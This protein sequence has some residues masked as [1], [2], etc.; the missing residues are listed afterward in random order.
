MAI[1]VTG[2]SGHLG[3]RVTEYLLE[4][5]PAEQLILVTRDPRSIAHYAEL[6]ATV[7]RGDFADRSSLADAFRGGTAML[8]IST[9]ALGSRVPQHQAAITAAAAAGIEFVAYTSF[10]RPDVA[11]PRELPDEH[12][13]TEDALKR[14]G[15]RWCI[16]RNS[17]YA[18]S[19]LQSLAI[20]RETGKLFTNYGTGRVGYVARDDCAAAAAA[21]L[22]TSGHDG[23]TYDVTGPEALDS[24]ARAEVFARVIG[25]PVEVVA[26]EAGADGDAMLVAALV[27]S[28]GLPPPAARMFASFGVAVRAGWLDLVSGSVADLTGRPPQTLGAAIGRA[29]QPAA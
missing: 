9:G 28:A 22:T 10:V 4:R 13:P 23:R 2:A 18:E 16:L 7:R 24:H 21:A 11:K 15:L 25:R 8:L 19:E 17:A 26:T 1:V 29:E 5:V 12:S 14:S 6:G 20:A 27:Q 3:R